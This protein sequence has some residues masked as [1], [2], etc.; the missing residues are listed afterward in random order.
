MAF[1]IINIDNTVL[2]TI[3]NKN[4]YTTTLVQ[5]ILIF[6]FFAISNTSEPLY[7]IFLFL[8][9]KRSNFHIFKWVICMDKF[10]RNKNL[11]IFLGVMLVAGI[12][13]GIIFSSV[14]SATDKTLITN[15]LNSFFNNINTNNFNYNDALIGTLLN[16]FLFVII[17]WLFGISIIG[18]PIIVFM[19]FAKSF[20]SGFIVSAFISNY[21]WKG[22]LYAFLYTFPH[23]LLSLLIYLILSMYALK[24]A[25]KMINSI[26][27]KESINFGKLMRFYVKVLIISLVSIT[28]T[29]LYEIYAVPYLIKLVI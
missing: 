14:L 15:Y 26:L 2:N 24:I 18:I 13:T 11:T 29:T 19:F 20:I 5:L 25:F 8:G 21:S 12:M 6:F 3:R 22:V 27:K 4:K 23:Q 28:L 9:I 7:N 10:K 16:N 17:M 1:Y